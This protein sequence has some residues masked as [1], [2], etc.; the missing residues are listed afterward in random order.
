MLAL[1]GFAV[2]HRIMSGFLEPVASRHGGLLRLYPDPPGMGLSSGEGVNSTLDVLDAVEHYVDETI[3]TQPFALIGESYG[4]YLAR[5]LARRR[6]KQ[7]T[8]LA[9]ICPIGTAVARD[10]RDSP[11]AEIRR[12][13]PTFWNTLHDTD[14]AAAESFG[15]LVVVRDAPTYERFASDIAPGLTRGDRTTQAR[16]TAAYA[17]ADPPESGRGPAF[18][19]P[20]LI[21]T[22]R[23]DMCVGYRD[24]LALLDHYPH[25]TFAVLDTAGHN[26][27]IERPEAVT[28]LVGDW[29]ERVGVDAGWAVKMCTTLISQHPSRFN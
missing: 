2:D 17:L 10:D 6:A 24:Q 19:G 1:H 16:I 27:Q 14:P 18:G 15:E 20:T 26:A 8:G 13:D 21:V 25:A 9:L 7:V 3:G 23:Q 11:A 5:A 29:L 28:A 4:G 12:T 22:G